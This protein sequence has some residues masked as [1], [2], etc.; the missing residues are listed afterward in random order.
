MA[1]LERAVDTGFACW[2]FFALDPR[3]ENLRARPEFR[4]LLA[5]LEQKYARR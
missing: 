1:W 5:G 4:S 2:P 3:L